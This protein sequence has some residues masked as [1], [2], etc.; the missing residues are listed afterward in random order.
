VQLLDL[1]A[2]ISFALAFAGSGNPEGREPTRKVSDRCGASQIVV[3]WRFEPWGPSGAFTWQSP[4]VGSAALAGW[5][6]TVV[7]RVA[8]RVA[9]QAAVATVLAN[10]RMG[11]PVP[12]E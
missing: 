9:Q 7:V 12:G 10:K 3:D 2:A 11:A 1:T 6:P 4:V 5:I 8:A